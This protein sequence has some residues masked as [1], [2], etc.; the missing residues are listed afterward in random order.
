LQNGN[1]D[2]VEEEDNPR[3]STAFDHTSESSKHLLQIEISSHSL[4][5]QNVTDHSVEAGKKKTDSNLWQL[6]DQLGG[7][8]YLSLTREGDQGLEDGHPWPGHGQRLSQSLPGLNGG[9][10]S[11]PVWDPRVSFPGW[12]RSG[13][14]DKT[15]K[16]S[17]LTVEFMSSYVCPVLVS[18]LA[19]SATLVVTMAILHWNY[20]ENNKRKVSKKMIILNHWGKQKPVESD[21][22]KLYVEELLDNKL[23]SQT[24]DEKKKEKPDG[25]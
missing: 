3:H 24:T 13:E 7:S 8:L 18:V 25:G 2:G 12:R 21:L 10:P 23:Q 17:Y 9:L 1:Q 20:V 22:E 4:Q 16:S 15:C 6:R 5:F 11:L 19:I 14:K